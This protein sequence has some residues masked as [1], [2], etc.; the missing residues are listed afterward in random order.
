MPGGL[1]LAGGPSSFPQLP[2]LAGN[3]SFPR[4]TLNS[5]V[6]LAFPAVVWHQGLAPSQTR[7]R[8][9]SPIGTST[10]GPE[11]GVLRP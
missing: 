2:L 3:S 1:S 6:M 8:A 9:V 5:L 11:F 4:L 10:R 7:P